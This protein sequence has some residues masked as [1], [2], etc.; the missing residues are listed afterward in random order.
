MSVPVVIY[1][2]RLATAAETPPDDPKLSGPGCQGVW[3]CLRD[4]SEREE[5]DPAD[6]ELMAIALEQRISEW[7]DERERRLVER[8]RR[9]RAYRSGR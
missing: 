8:F 9:L 2:P 6:A 7:L 1:P 3:R 4:L 5:D